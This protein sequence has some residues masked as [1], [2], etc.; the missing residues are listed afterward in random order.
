MGACFA[1]FCVSVA[2][3]FIKWLKLYLTVNH[4]IKSNI[5]ETYIE[6][7]ESPEKVRDELPDT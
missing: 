7:L 1:W 4:R 2:V 5:F 3:E 6:E